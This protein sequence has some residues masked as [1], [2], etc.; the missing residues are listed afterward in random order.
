MLWY[1]IKDRGAAEALARSLRRLNVPK[2]LR[3]E[4]MREAPAGAL[5]GSGLIVVNP[6]FTLEGELR[7]LQPALATAFSPRGRQRLDWLAAA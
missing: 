6:P 5:A 4:I 1:P 2:M 3:A 7:L